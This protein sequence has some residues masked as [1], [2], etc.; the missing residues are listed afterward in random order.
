M[1]RHSIINILMTCS[2]ISLFT[3]CEKDLEP[4]NNNDAWLNFHYI[5]W[6][7]GREE[8]M[9]ANSYYSFALVS[10]S[11]GGIELTQ[12]TVWLEVETMGFVSDQNRTI[13]LEQIKIEE[14]ELLKYGENEAVAGV[15]YVPF[16]NP[17]LL[18]KSYVPAGST[19]TKIPVV[20]LRDPSLD[21]KSV[22]LRISFKNNGIFKPGY[23]KYNTHTLHISSHLTKPESWDLNYLDYNFVKYTETIHELMIQWTGNAWDNDYVKEIAGSYDYLQYLR[24]FF[25][26][27]LKEVNAERLSQNLDILREPNGDPVKFEAASF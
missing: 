10:A 21:S 26:E 16:D 2:C 24:R 3:A 11:L 14:E 6:T 8:L 5:N 4:F 20:V 17:E 27:K 13:E 18:A 23:A 1:K 25:Q 22:A 7:G 12:D 15:H 19:I 9:Q